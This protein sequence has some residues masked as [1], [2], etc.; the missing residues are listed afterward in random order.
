MTRLIVVQSESDLLE[1]VLALSPTRR[2]ASLL[3]SGQQQCD[4]HG[5]NRDHDEQL[6]EG[7]AVFTTVSGQDEKTPGGMENKRKEALTHCG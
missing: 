2:L 4:Q 1:V 7:E 5:D 6:D 3:H